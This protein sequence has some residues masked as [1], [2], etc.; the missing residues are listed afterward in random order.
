MIVCIIFRHVSLTCTDEGDYLAFGLSGSEEK[1][2]ML[3]AD[4]AI[5]YIDGY[6]G[7]ANDYNITAN[8]PVSTADKVKRYFSTT[9]ASSF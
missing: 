9:A 6:R 2:Q 7:Y 8:S 1:T 3:G 5:A 4:V